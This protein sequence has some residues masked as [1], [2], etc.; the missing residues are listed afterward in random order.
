M[1]CQ[2]ADVCDTESSEG[3]EEG[4]PTYACGSLIT[5]LQDRPGKDFEDG[6]R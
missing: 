3:A 1:S 2:N 4:L 5:D 6:R